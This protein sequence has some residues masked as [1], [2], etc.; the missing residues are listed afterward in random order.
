MP[1]GRERSWIFGTTTHKIRWVFYKNKLVPRP[2]IADATV[3]IA[4]AIVPI[5][6]N[7]AAVTVPIVPGCTVSPE[8]LQRGRN[9]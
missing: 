5:G 8:G 7:F 3:G 4:V 6:A 9:L 1:L 2:H